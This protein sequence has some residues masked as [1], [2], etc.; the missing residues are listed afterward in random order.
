MLDGE[1][2]GC[3][4]SGGAVRAGR[5]PASAARRE[6]ILRA[7]A[8][9]TASACGMAGVV[10]EAALRERA[11]ALCADIGIRLGHSIAKT[12]NT[13]YLLHKKIR[14]PWKLTASAHQCAGSW[15]SDRTSPGR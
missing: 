11:G 4:P 8:R 15:L 3:A 1:P 2:P 14:V 12:I 6:Q 13:I 5:L 9:A 7:C 10:D